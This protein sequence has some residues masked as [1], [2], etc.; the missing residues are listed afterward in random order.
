M[1]PGIHL[2]HK[3]VG[4]TSFSLVQATIES[5][6]QAPGQG[7]PRVCHG[8]TLDPFAHGL[9][10]MLTGQA[11]RLFDHLHT[12]PKTYD[13]TVR[14]GME[15][16]NGDLLGKPTFTGDASTV[17]PER[18]D[19]AIATFVG[20]QEQIP[21]ATSAKR[22]GGERAYVKAH[23]GEVFEMPPSKVYLHEAKWLGHD[24]PNESRLRLVVRGGYFVRALS[25]DL[26]RMMGCGAHLTALHRT[27]IGPWVDPGPGEGVEIRGRELLP[28]AASRALSD[29]DLGDLRKGESI[30][31][32]TIMPP[33][34]AVPAGFP[35]PVA[36][37]RGFHLGKLAALLQFDDEGRLRMM[38][39]FRGGV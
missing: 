32:G 7:K 37:L 8:G 16:D 30:G 13:A 6:K 19:D 2:M 38:T 1:N 27:A 18:L 24:L 33:E 5:L 20:W 21:P 9:L 35:D 4:P 23:R 10:L 12:I 14:W 36:P 17:T 25:R 39:E 26:G 3:P 31:R 11:T 28:W 22:V 15:T 29:Q 34:W